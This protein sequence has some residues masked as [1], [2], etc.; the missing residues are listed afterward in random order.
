MTQENLF[1]MAIGGVIAIIGQYLWRNT[2]IFFQT[3]YYIKRWIL[4]WILRRKPKEMTEVDGGVLIP[5]EFR[6]LM[7]DRLLDTPMMKS[8]LIIPTGISM[9]SWDHKYDDPLTKLFMQGVQPDWSID[10]GKD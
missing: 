9:L 2:S 1:W 8:E 10:A 3:G 6:T 4:R 7:M 5:S